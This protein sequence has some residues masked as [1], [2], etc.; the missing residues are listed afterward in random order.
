MGE[1]WPWAKYLS[2]RSFVYLARDLTPSKLE[3]D[4]DYE[5]GIERVSIGYLAGLAVRP[6]LRDARVLTAFLLARTFLRY[7][8]AA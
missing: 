2:V 4:K 8:Q 1:L 5:I 7:Q 6:E 3:G